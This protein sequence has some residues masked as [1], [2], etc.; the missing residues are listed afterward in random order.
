[1]KLPQKFSFWFQSLTVLL[2]AAPL[3]FYTV[4]LLLSSESTLFVPIFAYIL[5]SSLLVVVVYYLGRNKMREERREQ[6]RAEVLSII[7][8]MSSTST[9]EPNE[10]KDFAKVIRLSQRTKK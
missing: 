1:V 4:S 3:L 7:E 9:S 6:I 8:E 10:S 5:V 2:A